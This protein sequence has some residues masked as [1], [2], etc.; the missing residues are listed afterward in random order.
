[1]S[2]HFK[3]L[4]WGILFQFISGSIVW[5]QNNTSPWPA[6]GAVGIGTSSP[7]GKLHVVDNGRN[8]YVNKAIPGQTLDA[9]GI[10]YMLLHKIYTGT[11]SIDRH[12]MGKISGVRGS[13]A[14]FNRKWTVEV[15]TS[16][17]YDANRGS[18]ISYNE[19]ARLV[20]LTYNDTAYMAVEII[21]GFRMTNFSFT[22]YANNESLLIITNGEATNVTP[23]TPNEPVL[24]QGSLAVG[25][26]ASAA[27]LHVD[28]AQG[29]AF[30]RFTQS[31]VPAGDAYL[32]IGN[33]TGAS[34]ILMPLIAARSN[35]PRPVGL[36][37]TA[38]TVDVIP[39][40]ADAVFAAIVLDG[41]SK[42]GSKLN[43]NNILAVNNYTQNLMIVKADG[44][45]GIG[46]TDTK[47]YLLAIGGSMIAEKI[48]VKIKT[49]WPDY[50]F[51]PGYELPRLEYI[52]KYI[53][54][55]QHLP[56]MP[57]AK[58]VAADG[59]DVAEMNKKLVQKVEELTLYLIEQ[60]KQM[61]QM[62]K[63]IEHL[64]SKAK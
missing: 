4:V 39:A 34:G 52:E 57:S 63:T 20:T 59:L 2:V 32:S 49:A 30:A 25:N 44:S 14:A 48:K 53:A 15:N 38:E 31:N 13:A 16:S 36:S 8:Y 50:V 3:F 55:H 21:S 10:N 11:L 19:P 60:Q 47:G 40:G 6:T 22:G 17:A 12:V 28:A 7:L 64:S 9:Q 5:G 27:K 33:S 43:N 26:N 42:V 62:K 61:D 1:M 24:I 51:T 37:I 45:V 23:F 54:D 29:T 41:R 46:A 35:T 56:D 18:I 58:E